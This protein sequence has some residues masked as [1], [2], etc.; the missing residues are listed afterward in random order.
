ME[1]MQKLQIMLKKQ[2]LQRMQ[3]LQMGQ[4]NFAKEPEKVCKKFK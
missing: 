1:R 2:K 3:R 4:K